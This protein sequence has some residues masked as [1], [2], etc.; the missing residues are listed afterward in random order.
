MRVQRFIYP[1]LTL[2]VLCLF[3]TTPVQA[4]DESSQP[5]PQFLYRDDTR[6]ILV[7]GYTGET[8]ELPFEV[9]NYD[10]FV[11][12]P[13]GLY[14]MTRLHNEENR[15]YCLNLYDVDAL[16]W[17][18]DEPISCSAGEAVFTLMLP[19]SF[20]QQ[21]TIQMPSCGCIP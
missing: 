1:V 10:R 21:T 13:D 17:L 3:P 5:A 18:Y 12:S 4:Q 6:L 8:T 9:T 7:D 14:L 15:A 20:T 11:W 19:T 2:I 16:E